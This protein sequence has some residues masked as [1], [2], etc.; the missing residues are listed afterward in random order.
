MSGFLFARVRAYRH[1]RVSIAVSISAAYVSQQA[2]M[3]AC[4]MHRSAT[5]ALPKWNH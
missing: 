5:L 4:P 1:S 2:S 3:H